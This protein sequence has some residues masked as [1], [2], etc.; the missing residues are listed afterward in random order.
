MASNALE[1]KIVGGKVDWGESF[2]SGLNNAAS[3]LIY[4]TN[5][6]GSLKSAVGRSAGVGAATAAINNL[7]GVV[8]SKRETGMY[9]SDMERGAHLGMAGVLRQPYG[10]R[11]SPGSACRKTSPFRQAVSYAAGRGYQSAAQR[12][13][14]PARRRQKAGFSL[15]SFLTDVAVGAVTNGLAGACFYG[16]GKAVSALT[17]GIRKSGGGSAASY[18]YNMVENPGPLADMPNNPASNFASG[19]YNMN[20]LPADTIFYR[21]GESGTPYGQWFTSAPANSAIQVRMDT[22]VKPQWINSSTGVLEGHS[23]VNANYAINI[24][25]GTTV[26]TGPVGY[27]GGA[28][29][30]GQD[31]LQTFIPKPWN[32]PGVKVISSKPLH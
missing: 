7:S 20:I 1:Q 32:I 4:G 17:D 8:R 31:I 29:L 19:K 15:K 18:K 28:Y 30:G 22:A 14:V 3:G 13:N 2:T 11:R 21:A 26:Y 23:Y 24:P 27:Q 5:P 25:K 6:F 12:M 9:G 10:G 16:T